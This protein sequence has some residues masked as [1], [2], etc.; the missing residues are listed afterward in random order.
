MKTIS[1]PLYGGTHINSACRDAKHLAVKHRALVRFTFNGIKL[2]AT[3][4]KSVSG[5][6]WE[7]YFTNERQI[8]AYKLSAAGRQAEAQR[9][10][11]QRAAQTVVDS[12]WRDI[13]EALA[14]GLDTLIAWLNWFIPASD[15]LGVKCDRKALSEK[16]KAAGY[17]SNI[18]AVEGG[19]RGK[20]S[21]RVKGEWIVGQVI[22]M[23]D[24][25]GS[26][27]PHLTSFCQRYLQ[28]GK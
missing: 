13:D 12:L 26:I 15:I 3:P 24:R 9:Q 5:L 22:N 7:F 8:A 4:K 18:H 11:E 25:V 27:H 10:L 19:F 21:K 2:V 6:I 14:E 16:L 20:I 28:E 17:V 1:M 23:I